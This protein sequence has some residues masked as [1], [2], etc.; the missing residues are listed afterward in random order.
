MNKDFAV[1]SLEKLFKQLKLKANVD[2]CKKENSFL[3]FDILLEPGG[4]FKKLERHSTEIALALKA[5]SEPLIYPITKKG[6]IRMEIM[7]SEQE[8]VFF[9]DVVKSKEF[10]FSNAQLPLALGKFRNGQAL[11]P[12]LYKMPHLLVSGATGSGKSILLQSIINSLL[13]SSKNVNLAL[14]DPKRVEFSYYDSLSTLYGPVARNVNSSIQLLKSLIIEMDKRFVILEKNNARDILSYNG[15]MPFIVVII[16]ELAD[17]MMA[18]KK[19]VQELVCRLAQKSRACGIHLI[20]A[21]QRPSVDVVTG[22]IKANF[23]ARISCQ[24]SSAID[25]RT[26]LDKNGAE[27]LVGKGD[28]I[29]NCSEY[30]FKRFKGSFLNEMEILDIVNNKTSLWSKIW[31]S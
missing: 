7:A 2:F 11:V 27:T 31:N 18:S 19:V 29:I 30:S 4:T 26:I 1:E 8:T 20:M 17:L 23:P 9:N 22:L 24:V 21:T 14:I 3:I 16:D 25:S 10:I 15:F 13:V 12:D 6:I 28:A 5:L